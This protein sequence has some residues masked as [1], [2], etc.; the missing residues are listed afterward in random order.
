MKK[1]E[2]LILKQY[3][4]SPLVI[5]LLKALVESPTDRLGASSEQM[6]SLLNID[7]M[8]GI[9]LDNIG[10]IIGQPRPFSFDDEDL[11]IDGLF[12]LGSISDPQPQYSQSHGFDAGRFIGDNSFN[13][14]DDYGYRLVLKSRIS[15]IYSKGTLAEIE[16]FSK[17]LL[18]GSIV[19]RDYTGYVWITVPYY[20]NKILQQIIKTNVGQAS[21]VGIKLSVNKAAHSS[22]KLSFAFDGRAGSLGFGGL[23]VPDSGGAF[24][25]LV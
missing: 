18:S 25:S 19:V 16:T 7:E 9:N 24:V 8:T 10:E 13:K 22:D 20:I 17:I 12:Q 5:S 15:A 2:E 14:I 6:I 21:G 3:E 11:Y 4:N 23:S 1:I